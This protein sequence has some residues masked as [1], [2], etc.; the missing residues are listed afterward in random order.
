VYAFEA[1]VR[2]AQRLQQGIGIMKVFFVGRCPYAGKHRQAAVEVINGL[3]VVHSV[4]C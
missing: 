2:I 1:M 4:A 3:P